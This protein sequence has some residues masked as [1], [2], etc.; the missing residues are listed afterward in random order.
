MKISLNQ[1]HTSR[2]YGFI[3]FQN[4]DAATEA[5]KHSENDEET[6]AMKFEAKDKNSIRKLGN[7]IY[8]KNIPVDMEED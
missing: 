6:V 8:F 5:I 2:G 7:N 1:D 3:C 4:E